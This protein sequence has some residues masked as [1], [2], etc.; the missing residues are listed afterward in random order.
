MAVAL[1]APNGPPVTGPHG[2]GHDLPKGRHTG[3]ATVGLGLGGRPFELLEE[4]SL[5]ATLHTSFCC[6]VS[7]Q[8]K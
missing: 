6:L 2:A 5:R 7:A 1:P 8:C 4:G 3:D